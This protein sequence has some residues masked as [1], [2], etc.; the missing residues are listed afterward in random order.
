MDQSAT[1]LTHSCKTLI[2]LTGTPSSWDSETLTTEAGK[3]S[4]R[5]MWA[6]KKKGQKGKRRT[7]EKKICIC[8]YK[9]QKKKRENPNAWSKC[10]EFFTGGWGTTLGQGIY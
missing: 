1:E 5:L 9:G 10:D 6:E 7:R 8:I 4:I 2:R 3:M